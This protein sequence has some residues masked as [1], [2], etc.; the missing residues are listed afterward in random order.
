MSDDNKPQDEAPKKPLRGFANPKN[1]KNINKAG[2]KPGTRNAVPTAKEIEDDFLKAS[3]R[4]LKKIL[5]LMD[6]GSENNQ[7]KAAFK[8]ADT[9]VQIIKDRNTL[10]IKKKNAKTGESES[11]TAETQKATGTDGGN[12]VKFI[13]TTYNEDKE[14]EDDED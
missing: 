13:S 7:L 9:S 12:V 8:L 2:R 5:E 11:Y 1:R 10:A 3:P 6:K 4:A 14:S